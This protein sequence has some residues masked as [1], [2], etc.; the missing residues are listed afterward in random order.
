MRSEMTQTTSNARDRRRRCTL[1][2]LAGLVRASAAPGLGQVRVQ[3]VARLQ[4]QRTNPLMGYGL[5]V[6]LEG[7]GDGGKNVVTMRALMQMHQRFAQPVVAPEEL[8]NN[9]SVAL[10]AVTAEVP[11]FGAREGQTLD[12]RI[13]A[14]GEARS[15]KGGTLLVTPLQYALFDPDRL[16]TQQIIALA[17]GRVET[18]EDGAA[19]SGV[20]RS[21][22][23][24]EQD[25]FYNFIDNGQV[26]LVLDDAHA[27]YPMAHAVARAINTELARPSEERRAGRQIVVREDIATAIGPRNVVVRIPA[28]ELA[29]PANYIRSVLRAVIFELP[30]QQARVTINKASRQVVLSGNVTIAPTILY[31]PGMGSVSL[32]GKPAESANEPGQAA[33]AP[34]QLDELLR[35][36]TQAA[37]P[38]A[39]VVRAIEDLHRSGALRAQLVYRD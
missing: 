2:A 12:V 37:V 19:T 9:K 15:L 14:L 16:E 31:V 8:K 1:A 26:T 6:G 34:V 38:P 23:V 11:E 35:L 22:A 30:E 27:G 25:F 5:V 20:I 39:Q 32:G 18:S 33:G 10:V 7:T 28:Y 4:G 3:D 13:A 21:G 17:S 29:G 36:M 24:L